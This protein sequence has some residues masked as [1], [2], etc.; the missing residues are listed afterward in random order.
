LSAVR[1]VLGVANVLIDL[2]CPFNSALSAKVLAA[3]PSKLLVFRNYQPSSSIPICYIATVSA[4]AVTINHHPTIIVSLVFP[5]KIDVSGSNLQ[6]LLYHCTLENVD[7]KER[8][9]VSA[10]LIISKLKEEDMEG[11]RVSNYNP[12]E[13]DNKMGS[14]G[15]KCPSGGA[16]GWRRAAV[17][18]AQ[19]NLALILY[20]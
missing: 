10:V 20:Q 2:S 6:V 5:T 13:L 3:S 15:W 14:F 8:S 17:M 7:T 12:K 18:K 11:G 19:A 16:M 9:E 1:K 4:I